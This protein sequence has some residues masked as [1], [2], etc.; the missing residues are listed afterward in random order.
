MCTYGIPNLCSAAATFLNPLHK[1]LPNGMLSWSLNSELIIEFIN[2]PLVNPRS[3]L[4]CSPWHAYIPV[5]DSFPVS[6]DKVW[7]FQDCVLPDEL[8]TPTHGHKAHITMAFFKKVETTIVDTLSWLT[9]KFDIYGN[10]PI[11]PS[12]N[13]LD[14]ELLRLF[15]GSYSEVS[16]ELWKLHRS[17]LVAWGYLI[18]CLVGTAQDWKEHALST[19]E[20]IC[21]IT[22][23]YLLGCPHRGLIIDSQNPPPF[24][25]IV[26]FLCHKVPVHY[27]WM[28]GCVHWLDPAALQSVD[29]HAQPA[30]SSAHK[31]ISPLAV[32]GPPTQDSSWRV[33]ELPMFSSQMHKEHVFLTSDTNATWTEITDQADIIHDLQQCC[34]TRLF[35]E[36]MGNILLIYDESEQVLPMGNPSCENDMTI[37]NLTPPASTPQSLSIPSLVCHFNPSLA[38]NNP[39]TQW[40]FQQFDRSYI[41]F[42]SDYTAPQI[43]HPEA[44]EFVTHGKLVVSKR[45]QA[46]LILWRTQHPQ[47][48]LLF[49]A[50]WCLSL[51]MDWRVFTPSSTPTLKPSIS[52]PANL[53]ATP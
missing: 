44:V 5:D 46:R 52:T 30:R 36:P 9:V 8:F 37:S 22:S 7:V 19:L 29:M 50:Y 4:A 3:L 15:E 13:L 49:L 35:T 39:K 27:Y 6:D 41:Y 40:I 25:D 21:N 33:G 1:S 10:P 43:P 48:P 16:M 53:Q 17:V 23:S 2:D 12:L 51:G 31:L 14:M 24:R 34:L 42:N 18:Y 11:E 38:L 26:M 32:E 47:V 20:F 28:L 45:T